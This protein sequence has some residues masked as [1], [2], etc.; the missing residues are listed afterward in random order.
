MGKLQPVNLPDGTQIL[1]EA[2]DNSISTSP[3]TG[4]TQSGE[5]TRGFISDATQQ[6]TQ[7]VQALETTIRAYTGYTLKAFRDLAIAEV[8]EVTL[9]FGIN[10][11]V[12]TG[13]PYIANGKAGCNT[14]ITVKCIFPPN[15][16]KTKGE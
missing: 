13:L 16:P 15:I 3:I 8:S 2:T 4:Q 11:D 6:V 10:V 12:Q 7:N 5:S 14:E 1:I 9:K